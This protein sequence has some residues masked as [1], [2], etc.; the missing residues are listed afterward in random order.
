M[1]F[2]K[3]NIEMLSLECNNGQKKDKHKLMASTEKLAILED[4]VN[5]S[6]NERQFE[7]AS[8]FWSQFYILTSRML[9]QTRRNK[10]VLIMQTI[11]HIFS[12]LALGTIF[13]GIGNDASMVRSNFNFCLAA[14]VFFVYTYAM[15]PVL[16]CKFFLKV[17][18]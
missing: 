1:H 8:N 13:M 3:A 15:V 17:K 11:H 16:T 18:K 2:D 9:L 12:A 10:S 5:E 7:F 6:Y 14:M 4:D